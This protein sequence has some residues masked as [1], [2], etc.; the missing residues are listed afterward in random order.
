MKIQ[1]THR[2]HL[3]L[4]L[5]A[6]ITLYAMGLPASL[7]AMEGTPQLSGMVTKV[8]GDRFTVHGDLGE[9]VTLRVT[10]DTN[11][12][13]AGG[14]GNQISTGR[15]AAKEQQEIPPTPHMEKQAK[16]G[17]TSGGVVMPEETQSASGK[18]SK[19]PSKLKDVVGSTD[20][21][22]NEDVAKG[23]GFAVGGKEGCLFKV[24]DQVK[25]E[26]SDTDTA[27]TIYQVS[28]AH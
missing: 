16:Q 3:A 17:T 21:K 25:I 18:L 9:E 10:K 6:A 27:T 20:P 28:Q 11:V 8:E 19:D 24:G 1:K 2:S 22:A 26:A 13:C 4:S 14:K 12:I 5:S 23:S 7:F 15:E